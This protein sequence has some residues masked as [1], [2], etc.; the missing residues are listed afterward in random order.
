MLCRLN[1][2]A[3]AGRRAFAHAG[4]QSHTEEVVQLEGEARHL[5]YHRTADEVWE[6]SGFCPYINDQAGVFGCTLINS[7]QIYHQGLY[8]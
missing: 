1:S 8:E 7:K 6:L 5:L 4:R 3:L 2:L